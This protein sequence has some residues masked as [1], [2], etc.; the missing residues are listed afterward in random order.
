MCSIK[1][2]LK[3]KLHGQVKAQNVFFTLDSLNEFLTRVMRS[4]HK[5]RKVSFT[6]DQLKR[7]TGERVAVAF[8][9]ISS[10]DS[11]VWHRVPVT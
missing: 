11:R 10:I 1:I 4:S 7:I 3:Y 5:G 2:Q 8:G 6:A 9:T